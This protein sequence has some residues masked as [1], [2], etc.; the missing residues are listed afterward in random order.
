MTHQ[1]PN[2]GVID[3]LPSWYITLGSRRS[4]ALYIELNHTVTPGNTLLRW[5]VLEAMSPR[6]TSSTHILPIHDSVHPFGHPYVRKRPHGQ[7]FNR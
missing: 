3:P 7:P 4:P 5:S 6:V 1:L 2:T